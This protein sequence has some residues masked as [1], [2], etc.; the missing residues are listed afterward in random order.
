[1]HRLAGEE[2]KQDG[3]EVDEAVGE[4]EGG[5]AHVPRRRGLEEGARAEV[6]GGDR[7]GGAAVNGM[8]L[9]YACCAGQAGIS[10][11]P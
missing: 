10:I 11:A 4:G 3:F 8:A 7:H 5:P 1:M 6:E 9:R 2:E